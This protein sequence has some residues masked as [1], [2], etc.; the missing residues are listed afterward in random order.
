M[1]A[2]AEDI[3]T[4]KGKVL[5]LVMRG[6]ITPKEATDYFE[7][8][9]GLNRSN[10]NECELARLKERVD[11]ETAKLDADGANGR[12]RKGGKR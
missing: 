11:A 6:V 9:S 2:K 4:R 1:K 10:M 8:L 5:R 12:S 7:D 3:A